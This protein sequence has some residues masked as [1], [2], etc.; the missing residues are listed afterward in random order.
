MF[1]QI[2]QLLIDNFKIDESRAGIDSTCPPDSFIFSAISFNDNGFLLEDKIGKGIVFP[3]NTVQNCYGRDDVL[4][5]L[6]I[7]MASKDEGV[8]IA[9]IEAAKHIVLNDINKTMEVI[10]KTKNN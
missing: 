1:Q 6:L 5:S 10:N 4:K 9:I 2:R 8:C 7:S 3:M